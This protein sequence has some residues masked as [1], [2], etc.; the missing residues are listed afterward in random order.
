MYV[1]TATDFQ[2]YKCTCI[3]ATYCI[4]A[5]V[6]VTY[7]TTTSVISVLLHKTEGEVECK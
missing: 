3:C 7:I 5:Y 6:I 4:A 1:D 2:N